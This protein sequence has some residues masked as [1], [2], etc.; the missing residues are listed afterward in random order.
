VSWLTNRR[1]HAIQRRYYRGDAT[2]IAEYFAALAR[3]RSA[4]RLPR[5]R[6]LHLGSGAYRIDGWLNVD[7]IE[8]KPDVAAD[9][10]AALPFVSDSV[11]YIHTE[12]FL[13]HVDLEHG[14]VFL[15]EC[16]R[17]LQHGGV[18]R[19]LTP[20]LDAL[21]RRVYLDRDR[22]HGAWCAHSFGTSTPA[23]ALNMHLRM[24]GDH[25]FVY[26]DELLA[27]EM[28]A[29]GFRVRRVRYNHSPDPFLRFLDV[30]DFGLNLF[31]EGVKG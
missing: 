18:L 27:R 22:R 4:L 7:R 2:A 8:E 6:A 1:L 10:A 5:K 25:R 30:R 24:N 29:A 3:A 28:K 26:D 19:L 13:E 31:F 9:L 12:D 21:V 16:F 17:V 20:D 11:D 14:R 23:E 15:R